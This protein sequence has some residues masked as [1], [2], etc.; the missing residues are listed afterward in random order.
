[1]PPA[2]RSR[3]RSESYTLAAIIPRCPPMRI[4]PLLFALSAMVPVTAPA[5]TVPVAPNL[6][7]D[8]VPPVPVSLVEDVRRYTEAR[9]AML[10]DWHP[11]RR[12]MLIV[13][14]FG[15]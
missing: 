6:V 4:L 8:S 11:K 3:T 14:R 9:L 5:Q 15:N 12:Q 10:A 13:T 7:V 1:M 2:I